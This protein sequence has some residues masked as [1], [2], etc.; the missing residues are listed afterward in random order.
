M[1]CMFFKL[2]ITF[3]FLDISSG[4]H[5]PWR[6]RPR[7]T[8]SLDEL[9]G[10]E[11]QIRNVCCKK[12]KQTLFIGKGSDGEDIEVDVGVCRQ[13]C[14]KKAPK[15][16][17]K[18]FERLLKETEPGVNPIELFLSLRRNDVFNSC[19]PGYTCSPSY[20][21][22]ERYYTID[23]ALDVPIIDSCQ[24]KKSLSDC[25]VADKPVLFFSGT[26]FE[27]FVNLGTCQADA[28]CSEDSTCVPTKN[29]TLSIEGPNGIQCVEVIEEC[30]CRPSCYRASKLE[31]IYDYTDVD[32]ESDKVKPEL[33]TIDIGICVGPCNLPSHKVKKCVL[34][35]P[36]NPKRCLSSLTHRP[37][38]CQPTSFKT[39]YYMDKHGNSRSVLAIRHCSCK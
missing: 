22:L 6:L 8:E 36:E 3:L 32:I 14:A 1:I 20:A 2:A 31:N 23:G 19:L 21:K 26:P 24:C 35:D 13:S 11:E 7:L 15:I 34:R 9:D 30:G 17:K 37:T 5:T 27:Q 33:Q 28:M 38:G 16:K 10:D 12:M 18:E 25:G 39:H 29:T 4:R